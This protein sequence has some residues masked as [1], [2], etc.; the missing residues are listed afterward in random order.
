M[1]KI[2]LLTCF[3]TITTLFAQ[4]SVDL[5]S[6]IP[7][8]STMV[9][10]I[11][12]K[13]LTQKVGM[14]NIAK[15][16]AFLKMLQ[17]EIFLGN[18]KKRITDIGI[19]L[20]KDVF[21]MYK[22]DKQITYTAYLYYIEKP[23][24]F[25]K[26][27][28]EKNEFVETVKSDNYTVIY[29]KP[30]D[31]YYRYNVEQDF[32]AW[33][34]Q[35]AIYVDV[36]YVQSEPL[37]ENELDETGYYEEPEIR[38]ADEVA[39]PVEYVDEIPEAVDAVIEPAVEP[40]GEGS[41]E[42]PRYGSAAY[43]QEREAQR[44]ARQK[45]QDSLRELENIAKLAYARGIYEIELNK[46]FGERTD[47]KS[48]KSNE[49]YTKSKNEKADVSFW[50]DLR[51]NGSIYSSMYN[52][53]G[54]Y[55]RYDMPG[56]L[57]M[58]MGAYAGKEM[59]GHLFFNNNDITVQSNVSFMP[60]IAELLQGIYN[61]KIPK[62]YLKYISN[63][64]VLGVTSAS[65]NSTKFW[66]AFPA[67]YAEALMF[68]S[69]GRPSEKEVEGVKVLVDF[70]SI[71][72][73]ESALGKLATGNAVFVLKD[74]VP[75][76]VEYYS[77]E[78]NED[79]TESKRVKK[80]KTEIFPDFLL[81]FGSENKDFMTKLLD[82]ACKNDMMY[83]NGNYY[84]TDGKDRDFPFQLYFTV[85]DE[86]AFVSTNLNE[87]QDLAAGKTTGSLDKDV[88]TNI[89]KNASYFNLNLP[90]LLSRIPKEQMSNR[91]LKMLTYFQN[92]GGEIEWINNY[93]N[94]HTTG[95]M[96]MNTPSKYKNSALFIWDLIETV[97]QF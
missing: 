36:N 66:E 41:G 79:Y 37:N 19:N 88:A 61:T 84:Y 42:G 74:L 78:Y 73:D 20:E 72:L 51:R 21:M 57:A 85:T 33:N 12:G 30:T 63:E 34:N 96:S 86:M 89:L 27:I 1:K 10:R 6:L 16:D 7:D 81:M 24:L 52:Y 44:L 39:P 94:D 23:K 75:T 59:N 68:G 92:N 55:R 2:I 70:V 38:M 46:F 76:E 29:Y 45:T 67:V 47:E 3:F 65:L 58:Y 60:E 4:N 54:Y 43:Y 91:E 28:A 31:D 14:K 93:D 87:I 18:D 49:S 62:S 35:Y 77:Y 5:E 97:D 71:M 22:A 15:S 56:M 17:G 82:L 26:Y 11:N 95:K 32:L 53:G 83:R 8:T 25:A 13:A 50:M 69:Y 9:V 64:K 48:I 40:A 90:E 80:T